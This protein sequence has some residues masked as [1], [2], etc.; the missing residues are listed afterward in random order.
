[1]R[2][3]IYRYGFNLSHSVS[4]MEKRNAVAAVSCA[5][6]AAVAA[7]SCVR[8]EWYWVAVSAFSI[9]AVGSHRIFGSDRG[10]RAPFLSWTIIPSVLQLA[11]VAADVWLLPLSDGTMRLSDI[12]VYTYLWSLSMS[13]QCFASGFTLSAAADAAGILT[14]GKAWMLVLSMMAAL[15][16]AGFFM[17]Y[18]YGWMYYSG[19]PVEGSQLPTFADLHRANGLMMTFPLVASLSGAVLFAAGYFGLKGVPKEALTEEIR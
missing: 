9:I 4:R 14:I 16:A 1:M 18:E 13:L 3:R 8:G 12:T 15:T 5:L 11:F 17:F 2:R 10:V 19:Y 7:V 6:S